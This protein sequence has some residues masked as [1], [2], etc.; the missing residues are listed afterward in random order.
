MQ[1]RTDIAFIPY[2]GMS[3]FV[4]DASI[5]LGDALKQLRSFHLQKVSIPQKKMWM[6]NPLSIK[7][8]GFWDMECEKRN[9]SNEL[10]R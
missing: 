6:M 10:A 4:C 9:E 7:L 1:L 8:Y 2:P 5:S 3:D